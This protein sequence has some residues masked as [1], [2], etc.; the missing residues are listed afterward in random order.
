MLT[1]VL[2]AMLS[3]IV[4]CL[5]L[6]FICCLLLW[7]ICWLLLQVLLLNIHYTSTVVSW[8]RRSMCTWVITCRLDF[9]YTY[10]CIRACNQRPLNL[11][12]LDLDLVAESANRLSCSE[13]WMVRYTPKKKETRA[14]LQYQVI[15]S[16]GVCGEYWYSTGS[17]E[18]P[19]RCKLISVQILLRPYRATSVTIAYT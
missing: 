2:L 7:F 8:L 10:T 19:H 14:D 11:C 17:L 12:P 18:S 4:C 9:T 16:Y 13:C 5:L 15:S 3:R 6:W 1:S